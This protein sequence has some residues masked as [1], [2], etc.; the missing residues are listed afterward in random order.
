MHSSASSRYCVQIADILDV[1]L[2]VEPFMVGTLKTFLKAFSQQ[3]RLEEDLDLQEIKW[4]REIVENERTKARIAADLPK[5]AVADAAQE[6]AD[7]AIKPTVH[8]QL[9]CVRQLCA[10]CVCR[11]LQNDVRKFR[12]RGSLRGVVLQSAV[13]K[14]GVWSVASSLVFCKGA[15]KCGRFTHVRVP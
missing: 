4:C 8:A 3:Y 9:Y 5:D 2:T 11:D 10:V 14:F 15:P 7:D 13:R 1:D 6:E 12:S